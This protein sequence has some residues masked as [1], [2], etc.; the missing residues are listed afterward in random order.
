MQLLQQKHYAAYSFKKPDAVLKQINQY[1][2]DFCNLFNQTPLIVAAWTGNVDE[3][4]FTAFQIALSL[5]DL[6]EKY[7]TKK[8]ALIYD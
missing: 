6:D 5:A 3:N 2:S 1:G 7:A 8:L 4:E